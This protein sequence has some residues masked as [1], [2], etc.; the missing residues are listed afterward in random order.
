MSV[1]S[2]VYCGSDRNLGHG[3]AGGRGPTRRRARMDAQFF[4][5]GAMRCAEISPSIARDARTT[6]MICTSAKRFVVIVRCWWGGR[7]FFRE[8]SPGVRSRGPNAPR[9]CRLRLRWAA[10]SL[11][12]PQKNAALVATTAKGAAWRKPA[13]KSG[14]LCCGPSGL[15]VPNEPAVKFVDGTGAPRASPTGLAERQRKWRQPIVPMCAAD[16]KRPADAAIRS[17]H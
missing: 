12:G 8:L 16:V 15:I 7:Q 14:A 13:G 4:L 17:A 9:G 10:S 3:E 11:T 5:R 6:G 1:H 2:K